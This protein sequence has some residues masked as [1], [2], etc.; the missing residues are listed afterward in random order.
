MAD[1][2]VVKKR[3]T[4]KKVVEDV[5]AEAVE[6]PVKKTRARK[7]TTKSL[8][9]SVAESVPTKEATSTKSTAT[10]KSAPSKVA[11]KS[12]TSKRT[13]KTLK[14][15]LDVEL[16]ASTLNTSTILNEATAFNKKPESAKKEMPDPS[17][18]PTK[19]KSQLKQVGS[20]KVSEPDEVQLPQTTA[21]TP[22][23]PNSFLTSFLNNPEP[24]P[25]P[26]PQTHQLA[27]SKE[28]RS[29]LRQA[30]KHAFEDS[31][32]S[33]T[34]KV[35]ASSP[36]GKTSPSNT[37]TEP[38]N[39]PTPTPPAT[40][41]TSQLHAHRGFTTT[42]FASL[43]PQPTSKGP[44]ISLSKPTPQPAKPT[45]PLPSN[46]QLRQHQPT[47]PPSRP[48]P[49]DPFTADIRSTPA[50]RSLYRKWMGIILASPIAIYTT[51]E[52]YRRWTVG[53]LVFD[54]GSQSME[55]DR[56]EGRKGAV[57]EM[58]MLG[59]GIRAER[60]SRKEGGAGLDDGEGKVGMGTGMRDV[61][62]GVAGS[63]KLKDEGVVGVG[64]KGAFPVGREG[65]ARPGS[66]NGV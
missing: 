47:R 42:S 15:D 17:S 49:T 23:K 64:W 27:D 37:S 19:A 16:D 63:E 28:G 39:M 55:R 6:V 29:D 53:E 48:P 33:S 50:Y 11:A 61:V 66:G 56:E 65:F 14:D 35:K 25:V 52:L 2:A 34:G 58:R 22:I 57:G 21:A 31:I 12:T 20:I 41:T 3:R 44:S 10:K 4:T 32:L 8:E 51:Y 59:E 30:T 45:I 60:Q 26:P 38:S 9:P 40:P 46:P 1:S 62:I 18:K 13:A 7:S 5:D 54:G 36:P 43:K 24:A